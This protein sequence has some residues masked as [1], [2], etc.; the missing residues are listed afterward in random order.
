MPNRRCRPSKTCSTT[1][2]AKSNPLYMRYLHFTE[3]KFR[4]LPL[5][6]L[7]LVALCLMASSS[8]AQDVTVPMPGDYV[9]PRAPAPP[10]QIPDPTAVLQDDGSTFAVPIPG[11]GDIVVQGPATETPA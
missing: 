9:A 5:S 8:L 10:E 11:G 1:N 3:M 6:G 4:F 7:A 2:S